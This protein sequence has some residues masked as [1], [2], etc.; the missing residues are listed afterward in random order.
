[1]F[2]PRKRPRT[3]LTAMSAVALAVCVGSCSAAERPAGAPP[4]PT[5]PTS[6]AV[7]VDQAIDAIEEGAVIL[8]VRTPEEYAAGHLRGSRNLDLADPRF[9]DQV[10]ELDQDLSYVVY[11]ATGNR[12]GQAIEVMRRKGITMVVNGGGYDQLVDQGVPTGNNS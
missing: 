9:A 4:A 10:K 6:T 5:A 1:M 7:A 8:D 11:C 12:A 2:S 3:L